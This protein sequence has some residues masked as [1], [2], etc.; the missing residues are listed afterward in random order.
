MPGHDGDI[1]WPVLRRIV[2]DWAGESAELAEVKPLIGGCINT[3]LLLVTHKGDR[4]VLKISQHRVNRAYEREAHQLELLRRF[5][6]PV[7]AVYRCH[8]GSLDHPDSFLL[9]EY[10]PGMNL[11]EAKTQLGPEDLDQLQVELA[12]LMVALHSHTDETYHRVTPEPS[13]TYTSWPRFFH[14]I[15]DP[16]WRET[17][18]SKLLPVKCRKQ[19]GKIHDRMDRLIGH[20]DVPR[21]VHWDFWSTNLLVRRDEGGRW[22]VAALLDPNCKYAH[23]E[24]E[25]AYMELFHTITPAF[26]R[27]YQQHRR[28][29][30]GYYRIRR[31]VYQ[32]YPLID[33][34]HLF[35][36]EYVK[37]LTE[38]VDR[39]SAVV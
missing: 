24:A 8:I 27:A 26:M 30:A 39:L 14:D 13:P 25:I 9:M 7:P 18:K 6:L 1:S 10:V 21:L 36:Q 33:H 37:P 38:V 22:R 5:E 11:A 20:N 12:E 31:A 28:M 17:E 19:I 34:V 32:L 4:A 35:G 3:T 16:I 23:A 29:D 2:Q 15:Y